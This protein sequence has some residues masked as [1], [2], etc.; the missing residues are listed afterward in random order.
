[1]AKKKQV[2]EA[3][4]IRLFSRTPTMS[5]DITQVNHDTQHRL[6]VAKEHYS[7]LANYVLYENPYYKYTKSTRERI[8]K[9]VDAELEAAWEAD[10]TI[11]EKARKLK[12]KADRLNPLSK[13]H[14]EY[15]DEFILTQTNS[16]LA[17]ARAYEKACN[18]II[19]M[20]KIEV[21]WTNPSWWGK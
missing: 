2:E 4:S 19:E 3:L 7:W 13:D 8:R 9:A 20:S 16:Y 6:N 5:R 15:W 11:G 1:M 21:P 10:R 12:N 17:Q 14:Q 18:A